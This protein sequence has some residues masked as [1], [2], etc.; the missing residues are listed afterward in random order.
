MQSKK[1]MYADT[2]NGKFDM[3]WEDVISLISDDERP[4]S[5]KSV[6]FIVGTDGA[7]YS[8]QDVADA[9]G[10]KVVGDEESGYYLEKMQTKIEHTP[11]PWTA[12]ETDDVDTMEI[13]T[14]YGPIASCIKDDPAF[15]TRA[16]NSHDALVEAVKVSL[17]FL[18]TQNHPRNIEEQIAFKNHQ[19]EILRAALKLAGKGE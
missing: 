17:E 5:S 9:I 7:S 14:K 13:Y 1:V 8:L 10:K 11:R 12:R 4:S 15:I 16:V 2:V 6:S 3:T 19:R 18:D